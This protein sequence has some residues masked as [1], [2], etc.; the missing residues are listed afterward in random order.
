M[1]RSLLGRNRRRKEAS[2]DDG[3]EVLRA[4]DAETKK[5]KKRHVSKIE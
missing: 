1:K 4:R 3:F 2:I 5:G